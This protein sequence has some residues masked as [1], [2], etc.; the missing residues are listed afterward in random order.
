MN[1]EKKNRR[2]RPRQDWRPHW[3]VDSM[4]KAGKIALSVLK[5][6]LGAFVTVLLITVVCGFV[7]VGILGDYLQE[8]ILPM[9]GMNIED[10]E[11]DKNSFMYYVDE[12]GDI[13]VYQ[14]IFATTSSNLDASI[15]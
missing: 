10:V 11:M 9:A 4:E 6:A 13:Q 7:F 12:N 1:E 15:C 5:V 8:D 3:S 2:N 14:Q